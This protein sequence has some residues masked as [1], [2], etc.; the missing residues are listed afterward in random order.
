M[1]KP[2]KPPYTA[3]LKPGGKQIRRNDTN[4]VRPKYIKDGR[5]TEDYKA[6][7]EELSVCY[8]LVGIGSHIMDR[9]LILIAGTPTNG[10]TRA[11]TDGTRIWLP[12]THPNRLVATK[13]ELSHIFFK[14]SLAMRLAFV[15]GMIEQFE[16][17]RG[18][19]IAG[20]L[21]Q[22]MTDDLCFFINILDDS[23]VN[24]LWGLIYPGDGRAMDEHYF[25]IVGPSMMKSANK[26][27]GGDIDHLF[28]YAILL[29]LEQPAKSSKWGEFE[30]DIIEARDEV[31]WTSFPACLVACRRLVEKIL[32]K[33]ADD[34]EARTPPDP[35]VGLDID[36][37]RVS[38]DLGDADDSGDKSNS[39]PT[40]QMLDK[41]AEKAK[42]IRKDKALQK[43]FQG[44]RPDRTFKS[45][46]A[47][48]DVENKVS[49]ADVDK[50][51][52]LA[53][54]LL[55]IDPQDDAAFAKFIDHAGEAGAQQ[56]QKIKKD[57]SKSR[58]DSSE[59]DYLRRAVKA[60]LQIVKVQKS[61]LR[62]A[63][64]E[65]EDII[66]AKK[67]RRMIHRVMGVL[68]TR[69]EMRGGVLS[70]GD[71]IRADLTGVPHPCYRNETSGRGF[72]LVISVDMS[73]SVG[74]S[75]FAQIERLVLILRKALDFPFVRIRV[76][77]WSSKSEGGVILYEYP[78]C[79][80]NEGLVSPE[81]KA[82]GV[83]PL[84][85]A[86]LLAGRTLLGSRN[87]RHV[88][89]ISDGHPVYKIKGWNQYMKTEALREWTREAVMDLQKQKVNV[90]CWMVGRGVP[91][92]KSMDFMFGPKR[93]KKIDEQ[94]LCKDGFDFLS[95][96]FLTYL[97]NR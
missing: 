48:F 9:K 41:I 51:A 13:H 63:H 15:R 58:K 69:M 33:I 70:T 57:I 94:E 10:V 38:K 7:T 97:R 31:L 88:F 4:G 78:D 59:G 46:N 50:A 12:K 52:A 23:R 26:T 71:Q 11:A 76:Q 44:K 45:D 20:H 82:G 75:L 40:Q 16:K 27:Y 42:E 3:Y 67:W 89:L 84:S 17:R 54:S 19:D 74:G 65:P 18:R 53:S 80:G 24:S 79:R 56:A 91:D 61:R 92:D 35:M 62:A 8:D 5:I 87:E 68:R 36:K 22:Q 95:G 1:S 90:W 43:I 66:A 28:T 93:W 32:S 14:S 21:K 30:A 72:D 25:G 6:W 2:R 60:D 86:V 39:A 81:S 77:G 47:G 73:S 64:L 83:T 96:Q 49:E 85:H 29:C 34:M 37:D 55:N